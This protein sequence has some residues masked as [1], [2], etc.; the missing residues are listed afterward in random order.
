MQLKQQLD[1]VLKK[2]VSRKEFLKHT[3]LGVVA[4]SGVGTALRMLSSESH[5]TQTGGYGSA[6]YGGTREPGSRPSGKKK[7]S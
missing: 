6:A 5:D 7:V 4:L 1:T 2:K 3:G